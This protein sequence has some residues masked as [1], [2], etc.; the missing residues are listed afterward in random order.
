MNIL[1]CLKQ[2]PDTE[3]QIIPNEA[4]NDIKRDNIKYV[5]NPYDEYAIEEAL[6]I[7]EAMKDVS[8]TAIAVGPERSKEAL[9]TAL[10]MGCD[11][12][13]LIV[14]SDDI[15]EPLHVSKILSAFAKT[16]EYSLILCGKQAI[17]DDS[18]SVGPALAGLM[19]WAQATNVIKL[20][21]AKDG[22]WARCSRQIESG[23][24]IIECTLPAV[25]TAQK[26]LNEPRYVS[27][28]GIM[29]AKKKEI[30]LIAVDTLS[31]GDLSPAF[32]IL[33][34]SRPPERKSEHRIFAGSI[35]QVVEQ[36]ISVLKE[37]VKVL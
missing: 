28:P 15:I 5:V 1:I 11:D 32:T 10:A 36:T 2:V 6:K 20:E 13:I 18:A 9:R 21:I 31:V 7:K 22:K 27:L 19:G 25:I 3:L 26:G 8:V 17:D 33:H 35:Q 34:F 14:H 23:T 30:P 12:A 24:A 29:K 16:K 4:E 37:E